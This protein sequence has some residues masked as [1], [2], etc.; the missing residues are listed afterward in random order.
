MSAKQTKPCVS[1]SAKGKEEPDKNCPACMASPGPDAVCRETV[2]GD[3]ATTITLS[4][5]IKV[6]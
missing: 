5:N 2:L 4:F 6:F 3:P 1:C